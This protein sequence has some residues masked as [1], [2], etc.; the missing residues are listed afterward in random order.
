MTAVNRKDANDVCVR[1]KLCAAL[2]LSALSI[3]C[4]KAPELRPDWAIVS[5]TV[6]FKGQPL[7]GGS[8]ILLS[9]QGTTAIMRGGAIRED[10]SFMLDA[11]IGPAK[12][13]IHNADIKERHPNRYVAIPAKYAD[14]DKSGLT[15][16]VKSGEN[17]DVNF[18]LL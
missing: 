3:G 4:D 8:V 13:A 17:K 7:P 5:G 11:P 16:E 9:Q 10:G 14:A 1:Q 12:V 18:E 15:Y 6:T 2:V